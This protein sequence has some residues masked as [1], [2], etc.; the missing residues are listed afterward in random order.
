MRDEKQ[1]IFF[2]FKLLKDLRIKKEIRKK[3]LK[4][5]QI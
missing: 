4:V 3:V 5:A 2:S 1:Q